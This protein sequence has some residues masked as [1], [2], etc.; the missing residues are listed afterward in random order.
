VGFEDRHLNTA[1]GAIMRINQRTA[2][3]DP[4]DGTTWRVGFVLLRHV[5]DD[6]AE[7]VV[8]RASRPH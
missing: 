5:V 1:V 6:C 8:E 3:I 2:T 4:G 7:S